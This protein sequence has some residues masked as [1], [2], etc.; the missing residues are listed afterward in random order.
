MNE[1]SVRF[2]IHDLWGAIKHR[3]PARIEYTMKNGD[4]ESVKFA[5]Q[6]LLHFVNIAKLLV[7]NM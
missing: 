7:E 4:I 1:T 5:K 3:G 2:A 6:A